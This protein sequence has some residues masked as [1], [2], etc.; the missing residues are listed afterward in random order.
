MRMYPIF[1]DG[2]KFYHSN[3]KSPDI[4]R[5]AYFSQYDITEWGKK[6]KHTLTAQQAHDG[7]HK[8]EDKT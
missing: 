6:E 1:T 3:G 4:S 2:K 5:F 7:Y 8:W